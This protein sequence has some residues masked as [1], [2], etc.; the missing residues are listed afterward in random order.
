MSSL[1]IDLVHI[2]G[3]VSEESVRLADC[4]NAKGAW[5]E[6]FPETECN[7]KTGLCDCPSGFFN[8]ANNTHPKCLRFSELPCVRNDDCPEVL[9]Q[10]KS[11]SVLLQTLCRK[12]TDGAKEKTILRK[13]CACPPKFRTNE[14][15][16]G[17]EQNS[18]CMQYPDYCENYPNT[19]CVDDER[20]NGQCKCDSNK[21]FVS[22]PFA[23]DYI[24]EMEVCT[25]KC[26]CDK[27][28]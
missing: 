6:L 19:T 20:G 9:L 1:E 17:C 14:D 26:C 16:D 25:C 18:D 3:F 28:D 13:T 24:P 12:V 21:G 23:K 10:A 27:F 15:Q 2:S 7:T 5:C 8:A 22:E 11:M 4:R